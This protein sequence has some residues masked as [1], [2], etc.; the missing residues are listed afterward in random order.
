MHGFGG[1]RDVRHRLVLD[2]SRTTREQKKLTHYNRLNTFVR[3]PEISPAGDKIVFE[4]AE[5]TGNVWM[6]QLK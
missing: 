5:T 1:E 6:T 2:I 3:Y 4:Y